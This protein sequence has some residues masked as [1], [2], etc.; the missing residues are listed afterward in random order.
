MTVE[1]QELLD[2]LSMEYWSLQG[3]SGPMESLSL[4]L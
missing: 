3:L 2:S 4:H 1:R